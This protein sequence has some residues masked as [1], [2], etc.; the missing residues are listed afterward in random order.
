M[1]LVTIQEMGRC[2]HPPCLRNR[3]FP[4]SVH[5]A[6]GVLGATNSMPVDLDVL[7]TRDGWILESRIDQQGGTE[8]GPL[9]IHPLLLRILSSAGSHGVLRSV[10]IIQE[11][12][13][14]GGRE[15]CHK[16]CNWGWKIGIWV[17]KSV[18]DK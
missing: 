13:S 10:E 5:L 11:S 6:L 1:M 3:F 4:K 12:S 2:N 15:I 14:S 9:P 16:P 8:V 17:R 18:S 7:D